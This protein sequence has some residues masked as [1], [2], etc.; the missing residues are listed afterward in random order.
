[1]YANKAMSEGIVYNAYE[2]NLFHQ[3][4]IHFVYC[5]SLSA[6]VIFIFYSP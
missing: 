3:N 5:V 1:M 2:K 6:A 4:I